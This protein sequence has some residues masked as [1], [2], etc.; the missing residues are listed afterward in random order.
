[1]RERLLLV[2]LAVLLCFVDVVGQAPATAG[3]KHVT[4][5]VVDCANPLGGL[6]YWN[7]STVLPYDEADQP[8]VMPMTRDGQ[9]WRIAW[10]AIAGGE[11]EIRSADVAQN[12]GTF[13]PFILER[14]AATMGSPQIA[15]TITSSGGL[16]TVLVWERAGP[17]N[18]VIRI[19]D[20][21]LNPPRAIA[22]G[23]LLRLRDLV[24]DAT[25]ASNYLM[26]YSAVVGLNLDV[27]VVRLGGAGNDVQTETLGPYGS[28][29]MCF[30]PAG[31]PD[32]LIAYDHAGL[33]RQIRGTTF[34]YPT[35]AQSVPYGTGCSP[36][37]LSAPYPFAG[38]HNFEVTV[39]GLTPNTPVV[40][41][42][43]VAAANVSL[44][45]LGIPCPLLVS[46]TVTFAAVGTAGAGVSFPIP[47]P[48]DPVF[49]GD[50]YVQA[51][52]PFASQATAGMRI[53][54]R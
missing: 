17:F 3:S 1:M 14:T 21:S 16:S 12:G 41:A 2:P 32:F 50:L 54:V 52:L 47:L 26:T 43:G 8:D 9:A 15:G 53:Q 31:E 49:V 51:I 34:V 45:P 39:G 30:E 28:V 4:C 20:F 46:P 48:D 25:T 5:T 23:P 11:H 38:N 44:Q 40:L 35:G 27:F 37:S 42:V 36:A 13:G 33:L 22:T 18:P 19:T 10:H 6:T 29:A 24:A 7:P